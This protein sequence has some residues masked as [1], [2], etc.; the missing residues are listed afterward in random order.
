MITGYT[1]SGYNQAQAAAIPQIGMEVLKGSEFA[2][3]LE[4]EQVRSGLFSLREAG[5]LYDRR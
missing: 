2:V 3:G 5:S 1:L 4:V